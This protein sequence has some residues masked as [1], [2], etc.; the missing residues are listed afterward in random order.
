MELKF[1]S[2]VWKNIT[3]PI[4]SI[5]RK[6]KGRVVPLLQ[7]D[8]IIEFNYTGNSQTVSYPVEEGYNITDFKIPEPDKVTIKGVI[9]S[10]GFV[11]LGGLGFSISG[12]SKQ[13]L[14]KATI[15]K[16]EVL[17][18]NLILVNFVS[19]NGILRENY[20]LESFSVAE[21]PDNYSLLEVDMNF[22]E[23]K[24]L[25]NNKLYKGNRAKAEKVSSGLAGVRRVS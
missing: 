8:S 7:F 2:K 11:G 12:A 24:L 3:N 15:K 14:I 19:R 18:D 22:I 6:D 23:V 13:D 21:T 10:R 9:S 25:A 20:T 4:Y 16:L 5:Y 1:L 17:K